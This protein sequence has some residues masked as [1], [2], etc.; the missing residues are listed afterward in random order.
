MR[1]KITIYKEHQ[2]KE[3]CS[4]VSWKTP[5]EVYSISDDKTVK[6]WDTKTKNPKVSVFKEFK[7]V[8]TCLDWLRSTRG[9]NDYLAVGFEDG[10]F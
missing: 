6:M 7:H 5:T 9:A 2:H 8:P 1:F 10:S 3:I 4:G